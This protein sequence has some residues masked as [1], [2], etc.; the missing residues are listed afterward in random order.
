MSNTANPYSETRAGTGSQQPSV[1][2]LFE[3][4]SH[5]RRRAVL[6]TLS[7]H[8]SVAVE[9]LAA[10]VAACESDDS[11]AVPSESLVDEVHVTLHHVHLPKLDDAGLVD[12]DRDEKTVETTS[13]A[14]AVP[15][16]VE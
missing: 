8:Q 15:V 11:P 10:D 9:S 7:D 3:I 4:L 12:Y 6:A 16:D 2:E 1:D 5:E 14:D 13:A